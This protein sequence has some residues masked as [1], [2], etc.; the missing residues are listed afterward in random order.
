MADIGTHWLDL[1]QFVSGESIAS[2][3]ADLRTVHPSA[4]GPA[5]VPRRSHVLRENS[6]KSER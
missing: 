4:I 1:I 5:V 3:C 6:R 2:V